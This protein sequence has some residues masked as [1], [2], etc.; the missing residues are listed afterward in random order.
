MQVTDVGGSKSLTSITCVLFKKMTDM[1][2]SEIFSKV[3][4]IVSA[5]MELPEEMI[6]SGCKSTE[7]VDARS[8]LVK[9]LHEVGIYPVQIARMMRKTPASIRYL[10]T[11]YEQRKNA[12]KIIEIYAQ[13]VRK[14]FENN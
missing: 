11:N 3:L 9:V 4:G 6:L 8:I 13:K 1:C 12:N 10:L 14:S 7:V 5:E 2:K